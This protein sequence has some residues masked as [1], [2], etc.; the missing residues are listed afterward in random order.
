MRRLIASALAALV[1][2]STPAFAV[3]AYL[4]S[5]E[6]QMSITG[7]PIWVGTYEVAGYGIVVYN[8]RSWCPAT[9]QV[10]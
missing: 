3:T 5:C 10:R 1:F 8:F 4:I 7:L 6:Q 9:I 2:A